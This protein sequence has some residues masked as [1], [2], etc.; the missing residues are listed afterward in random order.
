MWPDSRRGEVCPCPP[1]QWLTKVSSCRSET[2]PSPV[3][4]S[5]G[6]VGPSRGASA[7]RQ[8]RRAREDA[9][10]LGQRGR[11]CR[12]TQL[13]WLPRGLRADTS[14]FANTWLSC[15]K[16]CEPRI[17]ATWQAWINQ[18]G[19]TWTKVTGG[20]LSYPPSYPPCISIRTKWKCTHQ[21]QNKRVE[22][23]L[24]CCSTEDRTTLLY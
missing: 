21:L 11:H 17:M 20:M 9:E 15:R 14:R 8:Q 18:P 12:W 10:C 3:G 16:T 6:P 24:Q 4:I 7:L 23:R 13:T 2:D 5:P 22:R 1:G 19:F